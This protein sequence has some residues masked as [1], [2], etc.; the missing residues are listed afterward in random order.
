[1]AK[2]KS[3][4]PQADAITATVPLGE[5]RA[6]VK[7]MQAVQ[8]IDGWSGRI[9][10]ILSCL[11]I[12]ADPAGVSVKCYGTDAHGSANV[13]GE[14]TGAVMVPAKSLSLFL[15][16]ATGDTVRIEKT[17]H[18]QAVTFSTGVSFKCDLVPLPHIDA[19][20]SVA[21]ADM[22]GAAGF[23]L[24]EGVLA[25]LLALTRPFISTEE[26]RYYLNGVFFETDTSGL[27]LRAVATDGHRL[28]SRKVTLPAATK[29]EGKFIVPREAV[30]ALHK[31]IGGAEVRVSFTDTHVE[32]TGNGVFIRSKLIDGTFPDWRRV[33][34]QEFVTAVKAKTD[35]LMRAA[36]IAKFGE[37]SAALKF[38]PKDSGVTVS[39]R[40]HNG[41]TITAV[42]PGGRT[43]GEK[44]ITFGL[45]AK[46]VETAVRAIGEKAVEFLL[47]DSGGPMRLVP[48]GE[49]PEPFGG[50]IL[51]LMPMRV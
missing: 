16:H 25:H 49:R 26:T 20:T 19:A 38:E 35:A 21:Q 44:P 31:L 45:N 43:V 15:A 27:E 36:R 12:E 4:T 50:D 48:A 34:P 1:M 51:I 14:G 22:A 46:Y 29:P 32:F 18:D 9:I 28:G 17:K 8:R 7:K 5:L 30:D 33:V 6:A 3:N 47:N 23:A 37:R 42:V 41:D 39:G 13:G 40:S 2:K 10:P 24:G 11:A